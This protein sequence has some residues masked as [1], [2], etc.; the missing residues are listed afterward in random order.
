[1]QPNSNAYS[2]ESLDQ[3]LQASRLFAATVPELESLVAQRKHLAVSSAN[4]DKLNDTLA[5][6]LA[7][8]EQ[9]RHGIQV[10]RGD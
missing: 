9:V 1:M 5:M 3:I 10:Y 6:M 2:A 4:S 7:C 8:A